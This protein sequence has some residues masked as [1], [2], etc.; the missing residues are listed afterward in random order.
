[1]RVHHHIDD[2]PL[3]S[4]SYQNCSTQFGFQNN[5]DFEGALDAEI[6]RRT[7]ISDDLASKLERSR[8]L[9][10][11]DDFHWKESTHIDCQHACSHFVE[12]K[13]EDTYFTAIRGQITV[14]SAPVSRIGQHIHYSVLLGNPHQCITSELLWSSEPGAPGSWKARQGVLHGKL[15]KCVGST[16]LIAKIL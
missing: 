7:G 14:P 10:W 15:M 12:T 8:T 13:S 1:M 6:R 16:L 2:E 4:S 11:D 5:D 3:T 9:S